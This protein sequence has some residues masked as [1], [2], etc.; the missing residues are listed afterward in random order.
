MEA[1]GRA[2]AKRAS[3]SP[4]PEAADAELSVALLRLVARACAGAKRS[5]RSR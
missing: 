4:G 1:L 5:Y 2:E 3:A